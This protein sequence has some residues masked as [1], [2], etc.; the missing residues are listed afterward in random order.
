[1]TKSRSKSSKRW[2][3]R[4]HKDDYVKRAVAEGYRSRAAYKLLEINEKDRI[5][6]PGMTVI[7]LG[8]APGGWSQVAVKLVGKNNVVALDILPIDPIDGV[9]IIQGDFRDPVVY[10]D[11]L[12]KLGDKKVGLVISDM[13][14]N[15]SG[16][17][18]VDVL[19]AVYLAEIALDFAQDVLGPGACFLVKLFQGP[20]FTEYVQM[21]KQAFTTVNVRKPKASRSE[22]SE[23]YLLG[24]GFRAGG[25]IRKE[26]SLE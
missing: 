9:D 2:L 12:K 7:D 19:S 25:L 21:L 4:Q 16:I 8:A 22:S 24:T 11:L 14:P 18:S 26:V 5:F 20:G 15:F 3:E 17:S 6:R 13:A 1:M 10:Q 23:I